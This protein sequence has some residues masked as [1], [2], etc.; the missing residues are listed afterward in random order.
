MGT[1]K[2]KKEKKQKKEKKEK[3]REEGEEKEK[4]R[5]RRG[6]KPEEEAKKQLERAKL[7]SFD[8]YSWVRHRQHSDSGACNSGRFCHRFA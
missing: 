3:K 5:R 1:G 4:Q 8:G 2:E 7:Y 6:W